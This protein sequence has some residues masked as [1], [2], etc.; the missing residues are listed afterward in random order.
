LRVHS[1]G[2]SANW[3]P[4]Y[5]EASGDVA[6]GAASPCIAATTTDLRGNIAWI[7]QVKNEGKREGGGELG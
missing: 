1:P 2:S 3:P 4:S 7:S 5:R 6:P